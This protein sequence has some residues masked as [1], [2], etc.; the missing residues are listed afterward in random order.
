MKAV[1]VVGYRNVGKTTLVERLVPRLADRG[2][3]LTVKGIHHDVDVDEPGKDT[4]RHREAGADAVVGVTPS[5]TFEV[6]REGRQPPETGVETLAAILADAEPD[7]DFAV[8]EG[9]KQSSLP[10]IL[11]GD[12]DAS[13]VGGEVL[14]RVE[15]GEAADVAPLVDLVAGLDDWHPVDD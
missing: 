14:A 15:G 13:A 12:V 8:V 2:R 7:T 4:Y 5:F 10:K 9:F 1:G 11:V 3:V 6:R